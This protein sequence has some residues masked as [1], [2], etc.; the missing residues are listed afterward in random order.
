MALYK[1]TIKRTAVLR[2]VRIEKGMSVDVPCNHDPI[3]VNGGQVASDAFQRVYGID[4]KKI[5][6]ANRSYL[7]VVKVN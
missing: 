4:L 5:G 3:G 2:N 6:A 1:I 7:D